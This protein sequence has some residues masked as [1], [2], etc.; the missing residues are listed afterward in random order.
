MT[1]LIHTN[2]GQSKDDRTASIALFVTGLD[3][4]GEAA[5]LCRTWRG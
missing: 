4:M 5:R 3:T 2:L 1:T